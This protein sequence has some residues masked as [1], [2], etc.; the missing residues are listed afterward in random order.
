MLVR[1][2]AEVII[3][4]DMKSNFTVTINRCNSKNIVE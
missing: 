4:P 1:N 3:A 2:L